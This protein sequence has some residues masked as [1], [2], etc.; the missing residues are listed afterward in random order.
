MTQQDYNLVSINN[1][2]GYLSLREIDSNA[3]KNDVKLPENVLGDSI[4]VACKEGNE[5]LITYCFCFGRTLCFELQDSSQGVIAS[6]IN[7]RD[8]AL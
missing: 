7:M 2:D 8:I 3:E 5:L 4:K 1:D 6:N